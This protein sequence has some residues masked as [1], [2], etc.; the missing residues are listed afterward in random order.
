MPA[1]ILHV[2]IHGKPIGRRINPVIVTFA[3]C[4]FKNSAVR[5]IA[6]SISSGSAAVAKSSR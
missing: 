4:V 1:Q 5:F 6:A 3:A 2:H